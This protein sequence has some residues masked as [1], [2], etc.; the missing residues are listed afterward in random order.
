MSLLEE[1][2]EALDEKVHIVSDSNREQIMNDF[3][4]SFPFTEWGRIEWEKVKY[5]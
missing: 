2:M 3:E 1:C 5:H 4:V